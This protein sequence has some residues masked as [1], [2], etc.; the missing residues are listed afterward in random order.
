MF[1]DHTKNKGDLGVAKA[2]CDLVSK[3]FLVLTSLT[4][5]AS[6]DLV[7]YDGTR[8]RRIQVKYRNAV[9]GSITVRMENWWADK[10]GSHGKRISKDQIDLFCVYC[11]ETDECYYIDPAQV[12]TYIS[13]RISKP[14]N[15]QA[16]KLHL[17][18]D[19]RGVP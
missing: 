9:R 7:A 13:R 1:R 12:Q 18:E 16:K 14:R 8:F 5:H 2:H 11:P 6:F 19:F 4:E 10:N 3:G 17:A 15:N